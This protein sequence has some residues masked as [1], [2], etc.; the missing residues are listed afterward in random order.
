MCLLSKLVL[1]EGICLRTQP[2]TLGLR[3]ADSCSEE[4]HA[5]RSVIAGDGAVQTIKTVKSKT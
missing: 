4:T 1:E 2:L 5:Q 3:E